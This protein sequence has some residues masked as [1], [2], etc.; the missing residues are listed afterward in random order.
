M[1]YQVLE[2]AELVQALRGLA[3]VMLNQ[4][5]LTGVGCRILLNLLAAKLHLQLILECLGTVL[6]EL[7]EL[8]D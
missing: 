2:S 5:N 1:Q 8:L 4:P 7:E 6:A 3:E